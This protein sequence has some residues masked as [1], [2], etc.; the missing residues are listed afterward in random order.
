M[1]NVRYIITAIC[2]GELGLF[3]PNI[4]LQMHAEMLTAEIS[5]YRKYVLKNNKF[6]KWCMHY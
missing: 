3:L 2:N 6:E 1:D 4:D 5:V